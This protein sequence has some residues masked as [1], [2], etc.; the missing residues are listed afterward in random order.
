[1]N[2][3]ILVKPERQSVLTLETQMWDALAARLA[4]FTVSN[5]EQAAFATRKAKEIRD[6]WRAKEEERTS[7]SK[8]L[9]QAKAAH[10]ALFKPS[11][12]AMEKCKRLLEQAFAKYDLEREQARVRVLLESAAELAK[13]I[14]PTA[15]IPEPVHVEKAS[16]RHVWEPEIVDP[17]LVPREFC[18]PDLK[19]IKDATWY[20]DTVH[21]PPHPIPGVEFKLKSIVVAR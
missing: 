7:V 21:K 14:V 15:I 9:L 13:D 5:D 10:D 18:S 11:L 17:E 6:L 8:P 1:M 2:D 3:L 19:K 4:V 20:A 16:V 12:L